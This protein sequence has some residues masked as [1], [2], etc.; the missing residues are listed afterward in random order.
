MKIGKKIATKMERMRI[1]KKIVMRIHK[2]EKVASA[3]SLF[4]SLPDSPY[5][6]SSPLH[7]REGHMLSFLKQ[8]LE[9]KSPCSLPDVAI[10]PDL[11]VCVLAP[12]PDDFDAIAVTLRHLRKSGNPIELGVA[13]T[14]GGVLD[15]YRPGATL[16]DKTRLRE[17]E[18]RDSLAF[19]GLPDRH[20]TFLDMERDDAE[21]QPIDTPAN[22][23]LL[24]GFLSRT[25]PD[26]VFMPHGNDTNAG[27]Q[28]M[29]ALFD[30]AAR[31]HDC[32]SAAFLIRDPKTVD[33]Q[34]HAFT[35][36]DADVATWKAEMLRFHDT[37]HHRNLH[38]RGHGFDERILQVNRRIASDLALDAEYAEAFEIQVR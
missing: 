19:F 25:Q 7:E 4:T 9:H 26:I 12:H 27:H 13:P 30:R 34:V 2:D 23:Q 24:D 5:T 38:T 22:E 16:A 18:Q 29:Y 15:T 20:I 3:T 11:C 33:M 32:I 28:S 17:K 21:D 6:F 36:F 37:Q 35:P 1:G 31:R 14:G 8:I 10:P